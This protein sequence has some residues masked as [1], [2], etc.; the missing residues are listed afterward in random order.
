MPNCLWPW[1]IHTRAP[2]SF[3]L[4]DALRRAI[5]YL[6]AILRGAL[7]P[8]VVTYFNRWELDDGNARLIAHKLLM[9]HIRVTPSPFQEF[10]L[11]ENR[12]RIEAATHEETICQALA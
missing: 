1:E 12:K 11:S 10:Q 3:V 8:I 9:R 6:P 5:C 4:T 7:P 2:L